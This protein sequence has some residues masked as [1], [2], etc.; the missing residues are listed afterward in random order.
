MLPLS[1][2]R[3]PSRDKFAKRRINLYLRSSF[4]LL[5]T[6]YDHPGSSSSMRWPCEGL[7]NSTVDPKAW[8]CA[9]CGL[10]RLLVDS[11]GTS[12][13]SSQPTLSALMPLYKRIKERLMNPERYFS[14]SSTERSTPPSRID[15]ETIRLMHPPG[16]LPPTRPSRHSTLEI[17]RNLVYNVPTTSLPSRNSYHPASG[18][19]ASSCWHS[20]QVENSRFPVMSSSNIQ[21]NSWF[22]PVPILSPR[23]YSFEYQFGGTIG[24]GGFGKV[25]LAL[26]LETRREYAIKAI[27]IRRLR[28][29]SETLSIA[30]EIKVLKRIGETKAP[31]LAR[32]GLAKDWCWQYRGNIHLVMVGGIDSE[33][34]IQYS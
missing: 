21:D 16:T 5:K 8:F 23:T 7:V 25:M 24:E 33:L 17:P 9:N 2:W 20:L 28:S 1:S 27:S 34:T 30:N 26:H 3:L 14:N 22:I 15:L 29:R 10:L 11:S 32:P 19:S 18:F 13:T 31:F 12:L 4:Q 6:I